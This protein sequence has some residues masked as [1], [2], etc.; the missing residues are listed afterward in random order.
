MPKELRTPI[1]RDTYFMV[2]EFCVQIGT[3][4][5]KYDYLTGALPIFIDGFYFY[6]HPEHKPT[7]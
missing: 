1:S 3:N 7:Y 6:M 4:L 2:W 5:S